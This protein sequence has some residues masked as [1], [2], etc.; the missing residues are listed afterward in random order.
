MTETKI[1]KHMI[2][3][4]QPIVVK[5]HLR[6]TFESKFITDYRVLEIVNDWTLIVQSPD[7]KTR[8]ININDAKPVLARAVTD[9]ALPRF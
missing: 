9:T 2:L 4:S 6:N 5:N 1:S 8:Q 3:I 7:G